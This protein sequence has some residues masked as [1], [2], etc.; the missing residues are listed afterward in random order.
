ML[1]ILSGRLHVPDLRLSI[2]RTIEL[3]FRHARAR[4]EVIRKVAH[5][6][7]CKETRISRPASAPNRKR[8]P[9]KNNI[10]KRHRLI[11]GLVK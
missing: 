10:H 2:Q 11:I 6:T 4:R 5:K 8:R 9:T 3:R 1:V 7:S